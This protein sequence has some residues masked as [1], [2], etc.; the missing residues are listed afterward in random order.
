MNP[1]PLVGLLAAG[2]QSHLAPDALWVSPDSPQLQYV[3]R[4]GFAD[5]K[6]ASFHY[7]VSG[8]RA[9]FR[10]RSLA[11]RFEEDGYGPANSFGVRIDGGAEIPVQ[12]VANSDRTYVVAVGLDNKAH[13]VE[14]Y[15]RQDAYGGVAKFKGMYLDKGAT[16]LDPLARPKRKIEFYGDSVM[17]GS[18]T[19]A[20]GYEAKS[21]D[22]VA[23]DNSE[24]ILNNGYW[25][26]G[27]ISARRLR[28]EAHVQGIGGLSLLDHTGWFGG[29][30]ESC[31]GLEQ[32][33]DKLNP[34][35]GQQ[36]PWDFSRFTPDV[37]VLSIGQNDARGG[38]IEDPAWKK[39]WKE[40]YKKVLTGLKGHYPKAKFVLTTT[41][42]MHDLAWDKAIQEVAEEFNAGG[43][44]AHYYGFRRT[45][46]ATPGHPRLAEEEEMGAELATYLEHLPGLWGNKE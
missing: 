14:I 2:A 41:V 18:M 28:A 7:S 1:I 26:F 43:N 36:T 42:L 8:F 40:A 46:K 10:G 32:T 16:L 21:D 45:A 9:R 27:A 4:V 13:S 19:M 35:A 33:W 22:T 25:S 30:V 24:G 29:A 39:G 15:R 34:I 23:Y 37:V 12:L 31:I 20:F 3:G 38:H 44:Q 6:V 17:A 5:P 11:L